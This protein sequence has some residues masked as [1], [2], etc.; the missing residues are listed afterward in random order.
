MICERCKQRPATVHYTE[1]INNQKKQMNIC[2]VCAKDEQIASFNL[3]PQQNL[4]D[5]LAGIFG[6]G[7][8]VDQLQCPQCGLTGHK[9]SAHGLLGCSNCYQEFEDRIEPMIRRIQGTGVHTGKVPARSLGRYRVIREVEQLKKSL[10]ESVAREEFEK[11]AE[12]RDRI[13]ETEQKL[14]GEEYE[15]DHQAN[16]E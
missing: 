15:N 2:E 8:E 1:I 14:A 11:A 4:H 7:S 5:F 10:R 13:R 3:M 9:F 6:P 12:L 16:G